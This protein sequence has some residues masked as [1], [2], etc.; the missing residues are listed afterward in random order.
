MKHCFT[1]Q[2]MAHKWYMYSDDLKQGS[3]ML[4]TC[5]G[6]PGAVSLHAYDC[7][8]DAHLFCICFSNLFDMDIYNSISGT[9]RTQSWRLTVPKLRNPLHTPLTHTFLQTTCR[10]KIEPFPSIITP[11]HGPSER[12]PITP[13]S[14]SLTLWIVPHLTPSPLMR[15]TCMDLI[16]MLKP[17]A[18]NIL[19]KLQQL[20]LMHL[21]Y[22]LTD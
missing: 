13:L 2:C 21:Q 10:M 16:L 5:V 9:V 7:A 8:G 14:C 1:K 22:A 19:A 3:S 20:I 15:R 6:D 18:W 4:K 17:S 11:S 12:Q